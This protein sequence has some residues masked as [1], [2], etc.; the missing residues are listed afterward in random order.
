MLSSQDSRTIGLI[1]LLL[2]MLPYAVCKTFSSTVNKFPVTIESTVGYT[3]TKDT[4]TNKR[5]NEQFLSIK[6]GCYNER[7]FMPLLWK[8]RL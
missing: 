3:R 2:F 7:F 6:S 1:L 5:Y 4:T 8:V